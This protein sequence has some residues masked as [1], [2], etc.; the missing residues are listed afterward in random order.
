MK[1]LRIKLSVVVLIA[2]TFFGFIDRTA[3]NPPNDGSRKKKNVIKVLNFNHKAAE[4]EK[5]VNFY[6]EELGIRKQ[7]AIIVS[8]VRFSKSLNPHQLVHGTTHHSM[9]D[10][11]DVFT[12][13]I[14]DNLVHSLKMKTLAHEM[15]H[16]KQYI[17]KELIEH[18]H[19]HFS[20]LGVDYHDIREIEYTDRGWEKEALER[21]K[22][23][24]KASK[25][26]FL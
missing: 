5:Y 4:V 24:F 2:F 12:I 10:G 25:Q 7:V 9:A 16:V 1:T 14:S 20:W 8:F 18:Q 11:V 22:V 19:Y 15:V 3:I 6:I 13:L 17:K 21:E 23:L 26:R